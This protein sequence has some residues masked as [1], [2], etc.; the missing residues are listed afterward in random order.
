MTF[1]EKGRL[2]AS[3]NRAL[4]R[5]FGPKK[6]DVTGGWRKL[7]KEDL[8]DLYSAPGI[9]RIFEEDGVGRAHSSNG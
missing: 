2:G 1:R 4:R 3:E 9:I 6:D 8:R 5:I 7:Q